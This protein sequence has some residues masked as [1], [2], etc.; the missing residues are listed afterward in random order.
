MKQACLKEKKM[1]FG[2]WTVEK[3]MY[4]KMLPSYRKILCWIEKHSLNLKL[5]TNLSQEKSDKFAKEYNN[6]TCSLIIIKAM[7][8]KVSNNIIY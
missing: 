5:Q 7:F 2:T 4:V 6:Y 1:L 8:Q 3:L